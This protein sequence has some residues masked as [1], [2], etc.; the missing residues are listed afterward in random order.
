MG[1]NIIVTGGCRG[2]G[3]SITKKLLEHGAN[4]TA[5]YNSS[6]TGA[7]EL[8][9]EVKEYKG[10]LSTCKM[11]V[12]DG[13]EV[14]K[15]MGEILDSCQGEIDGLVN[16]AGITKDK[17][18]FMMTEEDWTDVM[19]TNLNGVYHVIK[20]V[21]LPMIQ[22][23]KGSIVNMASVS[24]LMGVAGQGNYCASKAAVIALTRTLSKEIA[25]KNVRVNAIAPG[26]IGTEMIENMT[27]K[28]LKAVKGKIPMGRV[29]TPEEVADSVLFLLSDSSAYITGHT[30]VVDGGLV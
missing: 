20:K 2:I 26:Y 9:K 15:V 16:N 29:G 7:L 13:Q 28:A 18:F 14:A 19:D 22:R 1:K 5:T 21:V 24:G 11:N 25:G 10:K 8:E 17:L 23:K 27:E 3:R 12:C 30:L 6:S 4:V